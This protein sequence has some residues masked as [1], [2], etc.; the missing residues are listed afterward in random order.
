MKTTFK[1]YHPWVN[2]LF[3]ISVIAFGMFFLHPAYLIISFS[4]AMVY[5]VRLKSKK[6]LK[7]VFAFLLP[8]LIFV[9]AINA[10]TGKYGQTVIYELA[11]GGKITLE[12]INYGFATGVMMVSVILWFFCMNEIVTTD[13]LMHVFGK[14]AP[15]AALVAALALRFV[16]LYR[17]KFKEISQAQQGLGLET[18]SKIKNSARCVSILITWALENAIETADSMRARGYGSKKR[19][20][21]SKYRKRKA[22]IVAGVIIILLDV[23]ILLGC[24][25]EAMFVSYTPNTIVNKAGLGEPYLIPSINLEINPLSTFQIAVLGAYFILCYLPI[26]LDVKEGLRWNKLK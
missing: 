10:L 18:Q 23:L 25:F 5:D 11:N 21:Y 8:M 12:A 17:K 24:F 3:F 26:I 22:D 19:I 7:E 13:K 15:K 14:K 16:P 6:A 9:T 20:T 4:A 1:E 2:V